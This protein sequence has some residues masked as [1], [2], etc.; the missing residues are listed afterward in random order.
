MSQ[1]MI[2]FKNEIFNVSTF[3]ALAYNKPIYEVRTKLLIKYGYENNEK[4]K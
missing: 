1:F 2:I 3:V 4:S